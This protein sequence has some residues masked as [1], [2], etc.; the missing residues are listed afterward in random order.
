MFF[1]LLLLNR[2]HEM[3]L[4]NYRGTRKIISS[5][6]N[7]KHEMFLNT[8]LLKPTVTSLKLNRKHEM[9]LNSVNPSLFQ[10]SIST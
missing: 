7:R 4:N 5:Q 2:K 6:L 3:F 9:F 1:H 10:A 8:G